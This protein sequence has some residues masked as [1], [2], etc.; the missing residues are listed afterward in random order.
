MHSTKA[1]TIEYL[2]NAYPFFSLLRRMH[3]EPKHFIDYL[4]AELGTSGSID[5]SQ[6]LVIKGRFQQKQIE[7]VV[8]RYIGK[9]EVS[10]SKNRKLI[11][12]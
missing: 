6:R 7:N 12:I 5:G 4:F 9:L 10:L 2:L 11:L 3:R 1:C 8:K